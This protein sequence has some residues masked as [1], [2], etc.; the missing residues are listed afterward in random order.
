M[1]RERKQKQPGAGG[2][3]KQPPV[4][5]RQVE[6]EARSHAEA[7]GCPVALTLAA[8]PP[9]QAG[10]H[11]GQGRR[12]GGAGAGQ[13]ALLPAKAQ[14]CP[15]GVVCHTHIYQIYTY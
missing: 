12:G 2:Q 10:H 9:P 6:G 7:G 1:L 15:R 13:H 11:P 5:H 4:P 14:H 3:P 8:P